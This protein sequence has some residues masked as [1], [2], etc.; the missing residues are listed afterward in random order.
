MVCIY[1]KSKTEIV[2]SRHLSRSN[3]T[4]RRRHCLKCGAIITTI[5]EA[6]YSRQ[7][8]VE[9]KNKRFKPFLRDKLYISIYKSLGHRKHAALDATGITQ[10]VI[11]KLNKLSTDGHL[12]SENIILTVTT[13]LTRFDKAGAVQYKAYHKD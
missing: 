8:A 1:C 9:D 7:W 5:E 3:G 12:T 11:S 10:T 13:C 4:W 6:D 2:N